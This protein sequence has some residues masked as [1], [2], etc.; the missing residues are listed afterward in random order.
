MKKLL[1]KTRTGLILAILFF[2]PVYLIKIQVGWVSFN[3]LEILIGA[4]FLVWLLG[5]NM[6]REIPEAKYLLPVALIF[7]GLILSVP[8][9]QN[10]YAGFGV[11]KGWFVFPILFSIVFF[12][13]LKRKEDLLRESL[14]TLFFSAVAVS[15]VGAIYEALGIL[16]YDGRL[17][18][19]WDSPNQ[20]AMF[21]AAP[22]LIGICLWEKKFGRGFGIFLIGLNL[23]YTFSYGA[24]MA[25]GIA[26]LVILWL[27]YGKIFPQKHL[28]IL[29]IIFI[30]LLSLAS[31]YKYENVTNMGNRSS[32]AS[33]LTIWKSAGLMVENSP[34]FG[35]GPG[36]FQ[37]KYLE[38]QEYFPPYLEWSVPQ[39]HNIFLAFWLESGLVGLAG[40]IMLLVYFFRDNKKAIQAN[41]DLGI[42]LLGIIIYVLIHG[43]VDT[44]YWR[45]DL[46][47][48]FWMVIVANIFLTRKK[49]KN[50]PLA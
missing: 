16:T 2:L 48:V 47:L 3:L 28:A 9:N 29:L 44:T 6:K 33:R 15:S 50:T 4:L 39:P 24:W 32:L 11:I 14:L 43:L 30:I 12:D 40:F 49:E 8:A 5:R 19:F 42:I 23:L 18:I 45:N 25:I 37:N 41:R 38:Y 13:E 17:K 7:T 34:L 10:Y 31:F 1:S 36:N 27:K 46:A 21:L 26:L 35:I 22:L 20:L